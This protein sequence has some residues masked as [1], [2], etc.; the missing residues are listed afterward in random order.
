MHPKLHAISEASVIIA[1]IATIPVIIVQRGGTPPTWVLIADW[2]IWLVFAG[3]LALG[4]Y[5]AEDRKVY[6]RNQPIDI[7]VVVLSFPLLP[8]LLALTRLIRMVRFIRVIR[9]ARVMAVG[10]RA[11]PALKATVGRREL[12]YVCSLSVILLIT[13]SVTLV[14]LEPDTVGNSFPNALWWS[15]VTVTTVGYGDISPVTFPGRVA[16][17]I[18]MLAGLGVI[19][20]LSA[21]VAAYFIDQGKQSDLKQIE[22]R[23]E[24]IENILERDLAERHSST[25]R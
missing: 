5:Y 14:V 12:L 13:A 23:L 25:R 7:A 20:T 21:S 19:S 24:R 10:V 6:L 9:V 22:E 1:A 15:V 18:V 8:S 2:A 16:A 17:I 3:A 11:I 4:T